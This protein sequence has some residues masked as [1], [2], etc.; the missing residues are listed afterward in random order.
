MQPV[1]FLSHGSPT[2][3]TEPNRTTAFWTRL[4]PLVAPEV[5]AV[6]CISAHWDAPAPRLAGAVPHPAI[7]HDFY[8]FSPALYAQSWPAQGDAALGRWLRE[9]LVAQGIPVLAEER[10]FDHGV[11][12]PFKYIWPAAPLPVFQLSLCVREGGPW[13]LALG[14]ALAP[15]RQAGVLIVGSGGITHNLG[16]I[17][18]HAPE[19]QAASWAVEFM[20]ALEQTLEAG[21]REALCHPWTLPHGRRAIPRWSITCPS[22]WL[23][24]LPARRAWRRNIA[25]GCSALWRCMPMAPTPCRPSGGAHLVGPTRGKPCAQLGRMPDGRRVRL[26]NR[27]M[28]GAVNPPWGR[29]LIRAMGRPE[30]HAGPSASRPAGN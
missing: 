28:I 3:L 6:L 29:Y 25:T 12:L 23:W 24:A 15:L 13:H 8:G 9:T 7:Q 26:A 27:G 20:T 22:W 5:R 11:W 10:P 1:W 2:F 14:E 4:A 21:D 30:R 17:H 16:E 18:W 19:G